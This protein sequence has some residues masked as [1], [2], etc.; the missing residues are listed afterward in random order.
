MHEDD[1]IFKRHGS[2]LLRWPAVGYLLFLDPNHYWVP[3][4]WP[5]FP[6]VGFFKI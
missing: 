5:M 2:F 3:H 6:E 1:S 4:F